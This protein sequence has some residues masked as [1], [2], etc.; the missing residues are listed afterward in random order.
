MEQIRRGRREFPLELGE[1]CT[2]IVEQKFSYFLYLSYT[3]FVR[4]RELNIL[5]EVR[6]NLVLLFRVKV[7]RNCFITIEYNHHFTQRLKS[8]KL[9]ISRCQQYQFCFFL[10]V[11]ITTKL[12]ITHRYAYR[13]LRNTKQEFISPT[14]VSIQCRSQTGYKQCHKN[15]SKSNNRYSQISFSFLFSSFF[16]FRTNTIQQSPL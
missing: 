14:A 11:A 12:K 8:N 13:A 10:F 5:D 6:L 1:W 4:T 2:R 7:A 3:V 16:A 15:A 9:W